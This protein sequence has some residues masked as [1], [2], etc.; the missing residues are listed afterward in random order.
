M[1][2]I[3]PKSAGRF[4]SGGQDGLSHVWAV[5]RPM[6][7]RIGTSSERD[8]VPPRHDRNLPRRM[9]TTPRASEPVPGT[10]RPAVTQPEVDVGRFRG[11]ELVVTGGHPQSNLP[12]TLRFTGRRGHAS[13]ARSTKRSRRKH[14]ERQSSYLVRSMSS[15]SAL[16][17]ERSLSQRLSSR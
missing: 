15:P 2:F 16:S 9:G 14:C 8:G 13:A 1:A 17:T 7:L 12:K 6:E 3:V 11:S 4:S 5:V 10:V